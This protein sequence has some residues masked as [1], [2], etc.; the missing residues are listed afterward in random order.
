VSANII[1]VTRIIAIGVLANYAPP[2]QQQRRNAMSCISIC[3]GRNGRWVMGQEQVEE[4]S[5]GDRGVESSG[6]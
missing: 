4:V 3:T 1:V 5:I 6:D 2:P